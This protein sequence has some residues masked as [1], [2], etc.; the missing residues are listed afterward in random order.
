MAKS[1]SHQ[2]ASIE[3]FLAHLP[4]HAPLRVIVGNSEVQGALAAFETA[5]ARAVAAQERYRA[6]GRRG[7]SAT[8]FG[9]LVGAF[10][11]FPLDHWV[12]GTPRTV[13][14]GFQTLALLTTFSATLLMTCLR[15]LDQWM[16][17]RAEAEYLRGKIFAAILGST[18]PAV[19][20]VKALMPQKLDLLMAAH[21]EDQ[22]LYFDKR[23]REHKRHASKFSPM[24]IIGYLLILYASA[25][26]LAAFAKG[27]SVPLLDSVNSLVELLVLPDANRW[28]LG[29]ATIASGI[30]AHA[31]A[32]ALMNED[33]RK[34]ELYTVTARKLRGLVDR[35]LSNVR[36]AAETGDEQLL[37]KFFSDARGILEQEHAVWSF[38]RTLDEGD[39]GAG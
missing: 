14:G 3:K 17:Y 34:A 1:S 31:T 21:I 27:L 39:D 4:A 8:T 25:L 2:R 15:P 5:D 29:I 10:L 22:L 16:S 24:R 19:P 11:L 9:I 6:W 37:E 7:L 30:L 23:A 26:G 13:I 32:R 38:I 18:V 35:Q 36:A 33:E 20:D 12:A 28:Q